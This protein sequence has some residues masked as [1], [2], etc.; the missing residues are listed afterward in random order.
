MLRVTVCSEFFCDPALWQH[1][2]QEFLPGLAAGGGVIRI[3]CC[4][5]G[6]GLE[7]YSLA[8]L[9]EDAALGGRYTVEAY[10][11]DPSSIE[12]A[13]AGG[14][15]TRRDARN[16]IDVERPRFF[17]EVG[18]GLVVKPSLRG[19]FDFRVDDVRHAALAGPYDLILYRNVEPHFSAA[20]NDRVCR[21]LF[22]ALRDG[23]ILFVSSVDRLD[24]W[25]DIGF[26]R[27]RRGF[28]RRPVPVSAA[29]G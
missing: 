15:Y 5:C 21:R 9:F 16:V 24:G 26:E 29:A 17:D 10:D 8:I 28:F 6:P 25:Q 12:T 22:G 3:L 23:G 7:P 14:P 27:L 18:G 2:E 1:L 20:E 13:I 19:P 11:S 4:G